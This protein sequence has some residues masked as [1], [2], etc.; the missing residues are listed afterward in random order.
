[1]SSKGMYNYLSVVTPNYNSTLSLKPQRIVTEMGNMNQ[2]VHLGDDGSEEKI[3]L[4]DTPIFYVTLE[5]D[6]ISESDSGTIFDWYFDIAKA[7]GIINSFKWEHAK[8]S[9]TYVARFDS[10]LTRA[11]NINGTYAI[12][13]LKLRIL[14]N[15]S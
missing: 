2:V 1:M 6:A 13:S 15:A 11:I 8:D 5:W 10:D 4:S 12:N 9:H 3:S 7:N 14:G